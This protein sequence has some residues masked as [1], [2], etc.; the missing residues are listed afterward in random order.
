MKERH[1]FIFCFMMGGQSFLSAA[2]SFALAGE[3]KAQ[4]RHFSLN[5]V[6]CNRTLIGESVN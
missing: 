2:D 5:V 3:T 4:E 1:L 6:H